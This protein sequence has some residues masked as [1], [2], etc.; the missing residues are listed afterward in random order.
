LPS[1]WKKPSAAIEATQV[2]DGRGMLD[3]ARTLAPCLRAASPLIES[4]RRV[5]EHLFR[6][7]AD[8]GVFKAYLP[9]RLGGRD[10][11]LSELAPVIEEIARADGSAGW[12]AYVG[13]EALRQTLQGEGLG[14]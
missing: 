1:G 3:A 10:A 4:E 12:L 13:S 9:A 6:A 2:T 14:A 11:T 5:P 7:L 8:I